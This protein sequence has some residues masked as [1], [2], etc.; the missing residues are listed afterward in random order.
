MPD[1]QDIDAFLRRP[2][3]VYDLPPELLLSLTVQGRNG[4]TRQQLQDSGYDD[5]I[6]QATT[7]GE[8]VPQSTSCKKCHV[9][10]KTVQEQR[11]HVKSDFHR[12]NLKLSLKQL[13]SVDEP[14]FMRMIGDLDESISG[15]EPEDSD[16]EDED[17][18]KDDPLS[19]L[20]KKQAKLSDVEGHQNVEVS[21]KTVAGNAP[22]IW[23]SSTK[24]DS[25]NLL[26]VYRAV[27]STEEQEGMKQSP[28]Q[29]LERKQVAPVHAKHGSKSQT[30]GVQNGTMSDPHYFLCMIGGGHFAAMIVSLIPE[31]RRGPG[32][33]EDR[34]AVVHAHKTFHRYTTRRKQGGSQSANDNA[35]G[36]AHSV[37]SSIRRANEAALEVEIRAILS[38]WRGMIDSAELLFI[39][40]TGSTNRRTLFGPYDGQV[41]STKDKRLRGFP[42]STRRATQAELIR[43]FQELTRLKVSKL[44]EIAPESA[45]LGATT[46]KSWKPRQEAPKPS[47][48]E[49]TAQL[50]TTQLQ[51]L[52][53]RS[54]APALLLYLTKNALSPNFP[55]FPPFSAEN[56]HAPTPL[57]LSASTNSPALITALLTK[58]HADPTI[59]NADGKTP[60]DLSGEQ[61]TRDAFRVARHT[62]GDN[63]FDWD[64][65]HIPSPLSQAEADR[66]AQAEQSALS[67]AEKQRRTADL[68]KLEEDEQQRNVNRMERKAGQG[69]TLSSTG[70]EKSGDEKREEEMRGLTPEM[71]MRLERERRARAAEERMKRMQ[72]GR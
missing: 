38:D 55:F 34:H 58:A 65:A 47:E 28:Q 18:T 5:S 29:I 42:F 35:K 53:R 15:S 44:V 14:T 23:M 9:S 24:I 71:R 56:H 67:E 49:A 70:Q 54:R 61:R 12:Y 4:T 16:D 39:R 7:Q 6:Q 43:S 37:G 62:L 10:F 36:N 64:A 52:V 69:K 22:M 19:A 59:M 31:I 3:Y 11:Q 30:N 17:E 21:R 41:L 13:P 50:H 33:M 40:A 45:K 2:L 48:E 72:S 25:D 8:E 26:G 32:G 27:F 51:S 46:P 60:Y 63:A 1:N 66:R 57:H 20:L 68:S